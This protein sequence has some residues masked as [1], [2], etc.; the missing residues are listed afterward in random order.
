MWGLS[1]L[2]FQNG[3]IV[4]DWVLFNEIDVMSQILRDDAP[5]ILG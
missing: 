2:Y 3:R 5:N 4:E 1:Q